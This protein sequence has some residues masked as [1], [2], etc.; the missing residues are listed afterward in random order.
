MAEADL[1][2]TRLTENQ[3]PVH[4]WLGYIKE[5]AELL[6]HDDEFTPDEKISIQIAAEHIRNAYEKGRFP[7][8]RPV[9]VLRHIL[10]ST[11]GKQVADWDFIDGS[12]Q[13][14]PEE[15]FYFSGVQIFLEDIR[16]P[17]NVGSIFRV[18]ESF[19]V[20][21]I[22]ISPLSA[23]PE[24][25]RATR[26]AMGCDSLVQWKPGRIEDVTGDIFALEKGGEDLD[27]FIFPQRGTMILGSEELG[28][29]P[30]A[31]TLCEKSKGRLTIPTVGLKGSLNVGTA[32]AIAMHEWCSRLLIGCA[33]SRT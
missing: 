31:L 8:R 15:R 30:A 16:S 17:F 26:S 29:S 7:D 5:T 1:R 11:V 20:E 4:S 9:N 27:S 12:G 22:L 25:P 21:L 19:G 24:H 14:I 13:F 6:A 2:L 33:Y 23:N 18:A 3:V 28:V 32:F 10:N